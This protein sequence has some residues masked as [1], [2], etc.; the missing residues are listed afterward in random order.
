[1]LPYRPISKK[2]RNIGPLLRPPFH[3][4][5]L[6]VAIRE[7]MRRTRPTTHDS[8]VIAV[9]PAKPGSGATAVA[10][11]IAAAAAAGFA[12]RRSCWRPTPRPGPSAYMLTWR[13]LISSPMPCK[14]ALIPKCNGKASS[15]AAMALT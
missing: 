13:Q 3:A 8:H 1:M 10:L 2:H 14:P 7:A 4:D 11:H 9:L 15:P 5:D 12:R 6:D